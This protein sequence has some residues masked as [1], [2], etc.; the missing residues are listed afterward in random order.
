MTHTKLIS[1]CLN[2]FPTPGVH[3]YALPSLQEDNQCLPDV[4]IREHTHTLVMCVPILRCML[5]QFM[6]SD[7]PVSYIGPRLGPDLILTR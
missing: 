4:Q 5:A 1:T 3:R 7:R 2:L 6:L